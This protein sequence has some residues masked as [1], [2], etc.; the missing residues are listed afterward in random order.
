MPAF[1]RFK[2]E[3]NGAEPAPLDILGMLGAKLQ[4]LTKTGVESSHES[5][6][7]HNK[8]IESLDTE[9]AKEGKKKTKGRGVP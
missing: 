9:T 5:T 1:K 7:R 4:K 6:S 8:E 2:Q 3:N